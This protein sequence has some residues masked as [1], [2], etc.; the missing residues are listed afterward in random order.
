MMTSEDAM[1]PGHGPHG[2]AEFHHHHAHAA[3]SR[4]PGQHHLLKVEDLT[5]SF[6]MYDEAQPFF[7]A[8]RVEREQLHDLCVSVHEGEVLAVVGASGS[9]K[10]LLADAIL[11]LYEKNARVSGRIW[12]DGEPSRP[13]HAGR[14]AGGRG[15]SASRA[16]CP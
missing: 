2:D 11:G 15:V 14:Q 13:A 5:V 1:A 12:F 9:G 16:R 7:R 6:T 8:G 4:H 3:G 10:T